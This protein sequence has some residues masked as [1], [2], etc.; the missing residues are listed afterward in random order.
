MI[1]N[2]ITMFTIF[3]IWQFPLLLCPLYE[4]I[5]TNGFIVWYLFT[6]FIIFMMLS[7]SIFN[8]IK[9][10]DITS[11]YMLYGINTYICY[12]AFS[13]FLFFFNNLF[14]SFLFSLL[15]LVF[16]TLFYLENRKTDKDNSIFVLPYL[17][18]LISLG[19][20]IILIIF[21]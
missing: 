15:S 5:Y 19:V 4:S 2:I 9:N 8:Y 18:W 10:N 11:N 17:F 20:T 16:G 13:I 12:S 21:F 14:Y 3:I 6:S 7:F 1:R